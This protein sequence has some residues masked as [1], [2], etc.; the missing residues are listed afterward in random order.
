MYYPC[1]GTG[2]DAISSQTYIRK[3]PYFYLLEIRV[4]QIVNPFADHPLFEVWGISPLSTLAGGE[5]KEPARRNQAFSLVKKTAL[6]ALYPSKNVDS[7]QV[8]ARVKW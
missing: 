6:L 2:L 7:Y 4:T 3:K 5:I 1:S 8:C